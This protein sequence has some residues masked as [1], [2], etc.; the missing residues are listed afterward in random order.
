[1]KKLKN[2]LILIFLFNIILQLFISNE[3]IH[4]IIYFSYELFIINVFPNLF[5]FLVLSNLL[6]NYGFVDMCNKLFT[7][8]MKKVF[9]INGNCS[10]IFIMSLLTGFPSNAKYTKE[11]LLNNKI[12]EL[13]A[14]KILMFTHFSNPLF[15]IGMISSFINM[16]SAVIILLCHYLGNIIIGILFRNLYTSNDHSN[17][18]QNKQENFGICFSKSI[19]NSIDTLLLIFGVMTCFL[20]FTSIIQNIFNLNPFFNA[21][22]G[23]ILEFTQGLKY[24]SLLQINIKIKAIIME[25][26]IS[27]GGISVHMQIL[28][29]ISDTKIKYKLFLIARI[30]HSLISGLLVYFLI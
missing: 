30:I 5:P 23:G 10:F 28:S 18:I 14:S 29:I 26:F 1:M 4:N 20:I 24:I 12:N 6:I 21:L 19:K 15:V 11:L 27:F 2:I 13:E 25:M 9:K 22:I 3:L 16:R 17:D 7:P 8:I